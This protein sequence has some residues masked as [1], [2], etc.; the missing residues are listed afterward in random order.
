MNLEECRKEIDS[1]DKELV[2]LF[3]KRMNVAKEVAEYKKANGKAVYDAERER[4][5][6]EKVEE[7]A[8]EEFGDYTRRLYS[9]ILELSKNY[10]N[11]SL[12]KSSP[13][14]K[15]ITSA[16][17]NTSKLFP[18]KA[19]VACQGVEGA[20]SS[21]ACQKLFEKP[22]IMYCQSFE[23]VFQAVQS[24]LCAYGV[25]PLENSSAGSLSTDHNSIVLSCGARGGSRESLGL[26]GDPTGP[27]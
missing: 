21:A 15:E 1:I 25:V 16:L 13:L 27:S 26:P 24:G 11:K 18:E 7:N 17:E 10:Q 2:E 6:L 12:A 8:G 4:K 23:A 9:S 14:S 20:H 19:V 5:L 3:V 22:S